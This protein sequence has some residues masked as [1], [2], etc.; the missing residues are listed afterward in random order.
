[1]WLQG[2]PGLW[3]VDLARGAKKAGTDPREESVGEGHPLCVWF[4]DSLAVC[5]RARPKV[6]VMALRT[7]IILKPLS[8]ILPMKVWFTRQTPRLH[9]RIQTSQNY[10]PPEVIHSLHEPRMVECS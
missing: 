8:L 7:E 3:L 1:M 9:Q 10:G 6:E 2:S 5:A 4:M